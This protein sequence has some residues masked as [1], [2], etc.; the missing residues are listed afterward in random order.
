M[1]KPDRRHFY[2]RPDAKAADGL[3]LYGLHAVRAALAN[4]RR[5]LKRMVLTARAAEEID[6]KLLGRVRHEIADG[7]TVARLVPA[8]AVHQGVAL[9]CEPLGHG[10]LESALAASPRRRIVLVLDQISDPHNAGAILRSAAAF[11]VSAVV[12]QDRH[13]PPE[14]G[15]LAKAA[16]GALD[17]VPVVTAVNIARALEH[18]GDLGFWRVA[19]AG[20]GEA[21]LKDAA[22][23]GD[24][25]LV[26]GSEGSGIRRLVRERCDTS[27]FVPIDAAMDSLNVSNAAAIALYE[28]R[29]G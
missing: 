24:I 18:L 11:G 27:A 22:G 25:A 16:S 4:P 6:A 12:V 19:L 14:S 3:W 7:D 9:S 10:D 26:L 21:P 2:P 28:L 23:T 13:A 8:G 5:K 29:R 17:I 15:A 20:D 1:T